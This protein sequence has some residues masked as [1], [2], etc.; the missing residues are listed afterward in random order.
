MKIRQCSINQQLNY[1]TRPEKSLL[2]YF[3]LINHD[4]IIGPT[5]I[6]SVLRQVLQEK[7]LEI[8]E[9]K[10]LIL[11][12]TDGVPTDNNGHQDTKTLEHALRHERHPISRIPVTIIACTDDDEC[13]G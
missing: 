13:I 4:I 11:I 10:L 7:Q 12:A 6:V 5:P 9:R 1:L 3:F 8:Q 2:I